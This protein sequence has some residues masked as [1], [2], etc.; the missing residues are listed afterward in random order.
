MDPQNDSFDIDPE[1][2]ASMGFASFGAQPSAKKRKFNHN[3]AIVDIAPAESKSGANATQL[4]I[5]RKQTTENDASNVGT[6]APATVE[7]QS[8][9][10]QQQ[11]EAHQL[12]AKP[13]STAPSSGP[14]PQ[15]RGPPRGGESEVYASIQGK[16]ITDLGPQELSALSK[17]VRNEVGDTVYFK[18]S[19]FEDP[20]ARLSSRSQG[21]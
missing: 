12:P 14:K 16:K 4:G 18:P 7:D 9:T 5:R 21:G 20:W 3:D 13:D 1:I 6:Q 11:G 10:E 19:F 8:T 2:A 15:D 17:G